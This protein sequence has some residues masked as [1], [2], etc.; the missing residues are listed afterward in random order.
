M[1]EQMQSKETLIAFSAFRFHYVN[2]LEHRYVTEYT[3]LTNMN[4]GFAGTD[5]FMRLECSNICMF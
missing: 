5:Y 4:N 1:K 2:I 3:S